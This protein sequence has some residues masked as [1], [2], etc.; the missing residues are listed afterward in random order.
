[1]QFDHLNRR[2]IALKKVA[3][4]V[5]QGPENDFKVKFEI[6]IIAFLTS[7]KSQFGL[8]KR[9]KVSSQ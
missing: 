7:S 5:G 1:M 8:V 9:Q 4:L 2:F 3:F 6:L